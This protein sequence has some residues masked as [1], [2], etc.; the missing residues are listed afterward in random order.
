MFG[1]AE[2]DR[3]AEDLPVV[4]PERVAVCRFRGVRGLYFGAPNDEAVSNHP[5]Y[6]RAS[7]STA[8]QVESSSWASRLADLAIKQ[9]AKP[10]PQR[11][12]THFI[13]TMHDKTFECVANEVSFELNSAR[14]AD[15]AADVLAGLKDR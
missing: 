11:Q 2:Q 3:P 10:M 6:E 8:F 4:G 9:D 14:L 13:V 15:V 5:L 7:A 12:M 1:V